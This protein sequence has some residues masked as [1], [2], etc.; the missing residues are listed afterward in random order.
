MIKKAKI[1]KKE[2]SKAE[3]KLIWS[4]F[5]MPKGKKFIKL[6]KKS[7]FVHPETD[8]EDNSEGVTPLQVKTFLDQKGLY[9]LTKLIKK[10]NKKASKGKYDKYI[11]D[12][13]ISWTKAFKKETGI[14]PEE[15]L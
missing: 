4:A 11:A 6:Q 2:F 14:K 15:I 8:V 7:P 9:E 3:L 10:M 12:G 1:W 13:F 5:N